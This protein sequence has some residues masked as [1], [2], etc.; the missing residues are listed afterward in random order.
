MAL[1]PEQLENL[2]KAELRALHDK[3]ALKQMTA[4]QNYGQHEDMSDLVVEHAELQVKKRKI[5]E[6]KKKLKFKF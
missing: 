4:K 6:E 2:T 5:Q 1:D 3:E